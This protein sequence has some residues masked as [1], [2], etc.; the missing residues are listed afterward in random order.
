VRSGRF[1]Q[2]G[3]VSLD[4]PDTSVAEQ[5]ADVSDNS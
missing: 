4:L 2:V 3:P 5:H 1:E